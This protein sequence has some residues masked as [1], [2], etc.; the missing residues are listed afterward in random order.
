MGIKHFSLFLLSLL[1]K[2][3]DFWDTRKVNPQVRTCTWK[4]FAIGASK[5]DSVP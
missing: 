5:L 3:R 2:A 1:K 4:G